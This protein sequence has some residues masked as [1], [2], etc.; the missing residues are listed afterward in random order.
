VTNHRP[1]RPPQT[2][3]SFFYRPFV[4]ASR[5][6][7]LQARLLAVMSIKANSKGEQQTMP[8]RKPGDST[9]THAQEHRPFVLASRVNQL[10]ARSLAVNQGEQ[11]RRTANNAGE[12]TGRQHKHTCPRTQYGNCRAMCCHAQAAAHLLLLLLFSLPCRRL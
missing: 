5:V 10:Q 4:L 3:C 7:Q 2:I 6:H 9:N 1:F 12:E 11:Q 8:G